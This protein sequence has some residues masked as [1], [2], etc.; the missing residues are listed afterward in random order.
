MMSL[1]NFVFYAGIIYFLKIAINLLWDIKD[2]FK[3]YVFPKIF[4]ID[5]LEK[6]GKWA[7]VTGCTQGIGKFY[8]EELAGKGL[9]IVLIARNQMRLEN[10]AKELTE[11]H[12][13]QLNI[14][15]LA[16]YQTK[17]INIKVICL[18]IHLEIKLE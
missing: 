12:G 2:G 15:N 14:F 8:A 13:K 1:D 4:K 7:V 9:N 16:F 10:V 6:Y 3:A 11:K 17:K 5:Y 18:D